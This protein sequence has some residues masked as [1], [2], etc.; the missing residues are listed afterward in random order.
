MSRD[1]LTLNA[2]CRAYAEGAINGGIGQSL[3]RLPYGPN[4]VR[5]ALTEAVRIGLI[6]YK[7]NPY[8]GWLTDRGTSQLEDDLRRRYIAARAK[9]WDF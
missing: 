3:L 7:S 4:T 6:G 5:S 2:L 9:R 8:D 1:R